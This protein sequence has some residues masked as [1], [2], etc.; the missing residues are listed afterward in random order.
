MKI[1][2]EIKQLKERVEILEETAK[3]IK[4]LKEMVNILKNWVCDFVEDNGGK[5]IGRR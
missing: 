3:E 5:V 2:K 4:Q 1:D